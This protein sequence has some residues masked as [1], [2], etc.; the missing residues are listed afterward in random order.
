[1]GGND[2]RVSYIGPKALRKSPSF[3]E[4]GG[5]KRRCCLS[6]CPSVYPM[7]QAKNGAY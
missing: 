6:V 7:P 3:H 2:R 5:I 4:S 1:M